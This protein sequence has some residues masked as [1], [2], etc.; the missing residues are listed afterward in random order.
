MK[1]G[2]NIH[3][4]VLGIQVTLVL[5]VGLCVALGVNGLLSQQLVRATP[6]Y[7]PPPPVATGAAQS[8][9]PPLDAL[10]YTRNLFNQ[11]ADPDALVPQP[12]PGAPPGYEPG[13]PVKPPESAGPPI[14][15]QHDKPLETDL[16][17][18]LLGTMVASH[19]SGSIAHIRTPQSNEDLY[20]RVGGKVPGARIEQI[21][22]EFVVLRR[23]DRPQG[24]VEILT[25]TGRGPGAGARTVAG[26]G[27]GASR[28]QISPPPVQAVTPKLEAEPAVYAG[29]R[30]FAEVPEGSVER[31]SESEIAISREVVHAQNSMP[32]DLSSAL[33]LEPMSDQGQTLGMRLGHVEP[34]SVFEQIGLQ[35]GDVIVNVNGSEALDPR[36]ASDFLQRLESEGEVVLEIDRRGERQKR[37]LRYR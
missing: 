17:L 29:N 16:A 3:I 6:S 23:D 18:H 28:A 9:P 2:K 19:P 30:V 32:G 12:V 21:S 13:F 27:G 37:Q 11:N 25:L 31:F 20:V 26:A 1:R 4:A 14:V 35:A 36:T 10:V 15:A 22:R 34:G 7:A 24:P 33:R 5:L 8:A